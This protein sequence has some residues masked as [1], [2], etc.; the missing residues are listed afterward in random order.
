MTK[1]INLPNGDAIRADVIFAVRLGDAIDATNN[2]RGFPPRVIVDF[3]KYDTGMGFMHANCVVCDCQTDEE[4]DALAATIRKK[5]EYPLIDDAKW[6]ECRAEVKRVEAYHVNAE[7][8]FRQQGDT[9][10]QAMALGVAMGC[11]V[12]LDSMPKESKK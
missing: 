12:A 9:E 6:E 1:F 11:R 5:L 2:T 10:K 4:R 3:G 7:M 8:M